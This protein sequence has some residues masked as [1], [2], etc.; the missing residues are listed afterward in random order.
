MAKKHLL[1]GAGAAKSTTRGERQQVNMTWTMIEVHCTAA[2]DCILN[3]F[4][5]N[6]TCPEAVLSPE[7]KKSRIRPHASRLTV[8][9]RNR[10]VTAETNPLVTGVCSANTCVVKVD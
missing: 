7:E 1:V 3:G 2:S 4:D 9:L 5:L 6:S 8:N 10:S